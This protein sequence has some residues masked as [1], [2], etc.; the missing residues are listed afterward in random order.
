M[1]VEEHKNLPKVAAELLDKLLSVSPE[2]QATW[3]EDEKSRYVQYCNAIKGEG[4]KNVGWTLSEWINNMPSEIHEFTGR[5]SQL[6]LEEFEEKRWIITWTED[7]KKAFHMLY[8]HFPLLPFPAEDVEKVVD[9][10]VERE[11]KEEAQRREREEAGWLEREGY[12][13]VIF[14][15]CPRHRTSRSRR[16]VYIVPFETQ[17]L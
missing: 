9:E 2:T 15:R 6:C 3:P 4:S 10:R 17:E 14:M 11:E 1:S 8:S 5:F 16:G 12:D 13:G 7:E